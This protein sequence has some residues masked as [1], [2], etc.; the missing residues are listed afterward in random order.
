VQRCT[1]TLQNTQLARLHSKTWI[2]MYSKKYKTSNVIGHHWCPKCKLWAGVAW[3]AYFC[4][5][6]YFSR[7]LMVTSYSFPFHVNFLCIQHGILL[8]SSAVLC[9]RVCI[10][11]L[12]VRG[13]P[14]WVLLQRFIMLR[15]F[16]IGKCGIVH[17]LCTTCV[18]KARASSSSRTSPWRKIM[19]SL[20]QLIWCAGNR[21]LCFGIDD[22]A[23][24]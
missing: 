14:W 8:A 23:Q 16:F 5:F 21:S 4:K 17:F 19:Y 1:A 3:A 12:P 22:K 13:A 2:L 7:H 10:V 11:C 20:T 6:F 24:G 18:F 9:M 15:L